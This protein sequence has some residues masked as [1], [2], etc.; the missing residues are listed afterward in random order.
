MN[1]VYLKKVLFSKGITMSQLADMIGINR[2]S[3]YSIVNGNPTIASVQ[4]ISEVLDIPIAK[5]TSNEEQQTEDDFG[6]PVLRLKSLMI[7]KGITNKK[8]SGIIGMTPEHVSMLTNEKS[9][10]QLSTLMLLAKG[11]SVHISELFQKGTQQDIYR[12][13][14]CGKSLE[15]S[16]SIK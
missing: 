15:V 5:L 1:K 12:C 7:E 9:N 2:T 13:P 14:H 10:P 16:I 3:L 6:E 8:L 4:K 11:L